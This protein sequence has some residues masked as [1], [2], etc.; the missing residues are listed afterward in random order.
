MHIREGKSKTRTIFLNLRNN[1]S[2]D[3]FKQTI[4]KSRN[5]KTIGTAQRK[6]R[7]NL[8]PKHPGILGSSLQSSDYSDLTES[9]YFYSIG[10][11]TLKKNLC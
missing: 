11:A 6:I 10:Y 4:K 2:C 7:L 8:F 3:K 5:E 1:Y 9:T